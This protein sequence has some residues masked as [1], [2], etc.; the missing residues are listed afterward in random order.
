MS[1]TVTVKTAIYILS[2]AMTII[3]SNYF[4]HCIN[5]LLCCFFMCIILPSIYLMMIKIKMQLQ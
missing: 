4:C 5:Y 3:T 2:S 1:L